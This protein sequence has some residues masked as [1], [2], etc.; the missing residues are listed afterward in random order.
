M[1][2]ALANGS[3]F[4]DNGNDVSKIGVIDHYDRYDDHR[5]PQLCYRLFDAEGNGVGFWL[6][7]TNDLVES[8]EIDA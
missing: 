6:D 7:S 3:V 5:N 4:D 1:K 2:Q 8:Y